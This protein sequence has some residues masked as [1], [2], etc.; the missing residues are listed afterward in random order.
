MKLNVYFPF[1]IRENLKIYNRIM[2]LGV[3]SIISN[4]PFTIMKYKRFLKK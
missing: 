1:R 4:A 2:K 3:R